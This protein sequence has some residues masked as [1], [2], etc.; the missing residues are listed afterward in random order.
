MFAQLRQIIAAQL[1][2]LG[3]WVQPTAGGGPGE[4]QKK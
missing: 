1:I 3:K 2:R 4:E